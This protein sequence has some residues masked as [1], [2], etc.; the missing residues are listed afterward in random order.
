VN[1]Y[2]P[3]ALAVAA[4]AALAPL[5]LA[6]AA[7]IANEAQILFDMH[8]GGP[9]L[10]GYISAFLV[11]VTVAAIRL[12]E[13]LSGKWVKDLLELFT[14]PAPP[15]AASARP[16]QSAPVVPASPVQSAPI[17]GAGGSSPAP[18]AP[19]PELPHFGQGGAPR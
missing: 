10:A 12:L 5:I 17:T 9:A 11:A 3:K 13:H 4:V 8:L 2:T 16:A 1:P 19:T 18:Q 15:P 14:P 6:F 7:F